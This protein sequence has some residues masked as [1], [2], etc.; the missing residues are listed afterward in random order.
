MDPREDI[1][2]ER[3]KNIRRIIA[4]SGG[5]G[6]IGKSLI[7]ST[8]ALKLSETGFKVGLLDLDFT[9]P[10]TPVSYTHLTLPTICSV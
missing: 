2:E 7:S 10:S 9:S 4:V 6:G 5:K 3:L 8:L 1:I